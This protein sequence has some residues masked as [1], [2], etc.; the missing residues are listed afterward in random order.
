MPEVN[1]PPVEMGTWYCV[2]LITGSNSRNGRRELELQPQIVGERTDS[3]QPSPQREGVRAPPEDASHAR[4]IVASNRAVRVGVMKRVQIAAE[5]NVVAVVP[6][7][8]QAEQAEPAT[9]VP[10]KAPGAERGKSREKHG[11]DG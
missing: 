11:P 10:H 3:E 7:M 4:Q 8:V 6:L 9:V 1:V 5:E 2:P